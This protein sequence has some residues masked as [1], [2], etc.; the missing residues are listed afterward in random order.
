MPCPRQFRGAG[1]GPDVERQSHLGDLLPH[2]GEKS[3]ET[4]AVILDP[5]REFFTLGQAHALTADTQITDLEIPVTIG[6]RPDDLDT[7]TAGASNFAGDHS[8]PTI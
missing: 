3:I 6:Q 4:A 7:V 5:S 8:L 2:Y 1:A